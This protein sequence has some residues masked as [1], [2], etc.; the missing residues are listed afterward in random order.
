MHALADRREF[1]NCKCDA[2]V[3]EHGQVA[4]GIHERSAA[5]H[6]TPDNPQHLALAK[7]TQVPPQCCNWIDIGQLRR[8]ARDKSRQLLLPACILNEQVASLQQIDKNP[9]RRTADVSSEIAR[10]PQLLQSGIQMGIVLDLREHLRKVLQCGNEAL[11]LAFEQN[12]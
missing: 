1:R 12:I 9:R 7:I 5:I 4:A 11:F 2:Y 3:G 8:H 10:N 6:I